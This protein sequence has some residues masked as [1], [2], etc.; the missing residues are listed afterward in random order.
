MYI[1]MCFVLSKKTSTFKGLTESQEMEQELAAQSLGTE[2]VYSPMS[3]PT[4]PLCY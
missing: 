4:A 2:V 3:R 1:Y